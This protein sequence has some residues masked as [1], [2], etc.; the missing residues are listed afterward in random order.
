MIHN[1]SSHSSPL[2][3]TMPTKNLLTA[4]RATLTARPP[5]DPKSNFEAFTSKLAAKDKL[6]AERHLAACEAEDDP[7]HAALW[8]RLACTLK[9]LA[10]HATKV[11]GRESIQFYEP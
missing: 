6:N 9:T 11:N 8:L 10:P 2:E 7:R 1:E 3:N 5:F 4:A